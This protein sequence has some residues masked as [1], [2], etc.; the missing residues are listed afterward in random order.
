M[1]TWQLVA[2]ERSRLAGDLSEPGVEVLQNRP[3]STVDKK[4][5][6]CATTKAWSSA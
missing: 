6:S 4:D 3:Q 2:T 5:S 1:D